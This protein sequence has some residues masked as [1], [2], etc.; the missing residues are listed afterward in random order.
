MPD[1]TV[2]ASRRQL[3]SGLRSKKSR[4]FSWA[5]N[6]VVPES[7]ADIASDAVVTQSAF[8]KDVSLGKSVVGAR[9]VGKRRFQWLQGALNALE[10]L[11]QSPD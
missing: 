10:A 9:V 6:P 5:S 4:K 3:T 8:L 7:K 2:Q 1:E 11:G